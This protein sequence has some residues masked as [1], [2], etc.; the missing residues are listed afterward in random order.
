MAYLS[1]SFSS[2]SVKGISDNEICFVYL[3]LLFYNNMRWLLVVGVVVYNAV[4]Y[5]TRDPDAGYFF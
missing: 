2:V 3:N 1:R 5:L 4:P